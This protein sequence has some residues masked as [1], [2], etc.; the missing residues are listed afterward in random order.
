M[1]FLGVCVR[2]RASEC[3]WL[4]AVNV[5]LCVPPSLMHGQCVYLVLFLS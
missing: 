3:V 2:A 5:C 1:N 4:V